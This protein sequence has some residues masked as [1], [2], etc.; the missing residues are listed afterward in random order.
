[1]SNSSRQPV[2]FTWTLDGTIASG[3]GA[4]RLASNNSLGET[5][6]YT[7]PDTGQG[8][9]FEVF[10]NGGLNAAEPGRLLRCASGSPPSPTPWDVLGNGVTDVN[11]LILVG[12]S[13]Q[14][15]GPPAWIV[16]D[17]VP[18]GIIDVND[19]VE[20]GKHWGQ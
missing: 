7:T 6:V 12:E 1:V 20:V 5:Y 17:V 10:V 18:D 15:T 3:S 8:N 16:E 19:L 2:P 9:Q 13:W 14:L 4:A 11:D